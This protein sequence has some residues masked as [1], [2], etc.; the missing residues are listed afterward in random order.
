MVDEKRLPDRIGL[1][2]F[3]HRPELVAGQIELPEALGDQ[4]VIDEQFI[5]PPQQQF[6]E[7]GIVEMRVDVE[8]G[9][10]FDD[11]GNEGSDVCGG[12]HNRRNLRAILVAPKLKIFP[13]MTDMLHQLKR[14]IARGDLSHVRDLLGKSTGEKITKSPAEAAQ[15]LVAAIYQNESGAGLVSLL[16]AAGFSADAV[17]DGLKGYEQTPFMAAAKAGRVDLMKL[18]VSHGADPHWKSPAGANAASKVLECRWNGSDRCLTQAVADY[19]AELGVVID[20]LSTDSEHQLFYAAYGKKTWPR[21]PELLRLGIPSDGLRWTSLMFKIALGEATISDVSHMAEDLEHKDDW[22][23]TVFLLSIVAD[24]GDIAEA[25]LQQGSD[26]HT[27]GRCGMNVLHYAAMF[28]HEEMIAWLLSL[29]LAVDSLGEYGD[30]PLMSAAGSESLA[31]AKRLLTEGACV[32]AEDR[33]GFQAIHEAS[34]IEMIKLLIE[35]G[36]DV[37]AVSGGGDWPL[38]EAASARDA[39]L[40]RYLLEVGA[41]VNLP[42]TGETALFGAVRSDS[43]ECVTLLLD[44]GA[45]VNAQDCDGWTCLWCVESEPIARLLL[46]RGADASLADQCGGV[47]ESWALPPQVTALFREHR[48]QNFREKS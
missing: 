30:T 8:D 25:L 36:A 39:A 17:D 44:S 40:I 20:P 35:A 37:N 43:M 15:L 13:A 33:N 48:L 29:G 3:R 14:A 10:G 2:R 18:L 7:R 42:S 19:V 34:G 38:K 26:L 5:N 47:P 1:L 31:A 6:A 4:V 27:K 9:R 22:D 16:L 46:D 11:I 23:R 21:I 41:N 12:L 45:E 24:R 28:D 32:R